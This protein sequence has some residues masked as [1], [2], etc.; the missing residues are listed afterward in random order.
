MLICCNE[1]YGKLHLK[2]KEIVNLCNCLQS[3]KQHEVLSYVSK[4]SITMVMRQGF[5]TF[6]PQSTTYILS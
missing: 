5:S 6:V 1:N 2:D 3:T 4:Y